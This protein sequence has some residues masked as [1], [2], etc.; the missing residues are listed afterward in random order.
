MEELSFFYHRRSVAIAIIYSAYRR[1]EE[2]DQDQAAEQVNPGSNTPPPP[3]KPSR[4]AHKGTRPANAPF[5][6]A[7]PPKKTRH[8]KQCSCSSKTS[9]APATTEQA[10]QARAAPT[11]APNTSPVGTAPPSRSPSSDHE[12][13]TPLQQNVTTQDASVQVEE[14]ELEPEQPIFVQGSTIPMRYSTQY[15]QQNL[16]NDVIG[17]LYAAEEQQ[18]QP[19]EGADNADDAAIPYKQVLKFWQ[20][21]ANQGGVSSDSDDDQEE[22]DLG[23]NNTAQQQSVNIRP[24]Y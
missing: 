18:E 12:A 9:T 21:K 3:P 11:R 8:S 19:Q 15:C 7:D 1:V 10:N 24:I 20:D 5:P 23:D 14:Q 17:S 4:A 16:E 13:V 6:P 22:I 2:E